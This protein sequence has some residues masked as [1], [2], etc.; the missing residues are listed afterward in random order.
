M[1]DTL[2]I[3]QPRPFD[4]VDHTILIAGNAVAFEGTLTIKV[5]EGHDEYSS[6]TQV[7]ALAL[8]QFQGSITIPENNAFKL[9]RLLLRLADDTGN[10]DGPVVF[11]PILFGPLIL[12]G[13]GGYRLYT[14]RRGDNLTKIAQAE[15]GTDNFQPIFQANQH[16]I[17][18]PN[19]IFPG[20]VLRIPRTDV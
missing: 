6:F 20:Q 19:L 1:V 12:P 11:I 9:N 4:L 2:D 3:Q 18:D 7:G 15:Y 13:Y 14:V 8:R 5:G 10:E 16:I 17:D